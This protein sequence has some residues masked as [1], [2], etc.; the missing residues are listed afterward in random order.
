MIPLFL[1]VSVFSFV[2][3][4]ELYVFFS[5]IPFLINY[6][7]TYQKKKKKKKNSL[8]V[9]IEPKKAKVQNAYAMSHCNSK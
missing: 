8:E 4:C 1:F 6:F 9:P 5:S 2:H 3:Y 7:L